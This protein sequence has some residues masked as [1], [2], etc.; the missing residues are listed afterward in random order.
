MEF[1]S[2]SSDFVVVVVVV[3]V[4][5]GVKSVQPTISLFRK[6]MKVLS[7]KTK[8]WSFAESCCVSMSNSAERLKVTVLVSFSF[9]AELVI[10]ISIFP[11]L[12][13][14][15]EKVVCLRLAGKEERGKRKKKRKMNK[16]KC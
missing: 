9:S 16:K 4:K 5:K 13:H 7:S 2:P 6:V 14:T 12:A 8:P 10:E 1:V 15:N 11:G 3:A